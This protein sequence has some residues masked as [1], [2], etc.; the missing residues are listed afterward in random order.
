MSIVNITENGILYGNPRLPIND[1]TTEEVLLITDEIIKIYTY[2]EDYLAF[3]QVLKIINTLP[4]EIQMF[5]CKPI[6]YGFLGIK[7]IVKNV[8]KYDLKMSLSQ[9]LKF[10]YSI[11]FKMG[12]TKHSFKNKPLKYN[13]KKILKFIHTFEFLMKENIYI[14]DVKLD[15]II[16]YNDTFKFIDYQDLNY[17][18]I[19]LIDYINKSIC[20]NITYFVYP[21]D[22]QLFLCNTREIPEDPVN[23]R[24]KRKIINKFINLLKKIKFKK[25]ILFF[26][27]NEYIKIKTHYKNVEVSLKKIDILEHI[28][29]I[30]DITLNEVQ[31]YS[32]GMLLIELLLLY[33]THNDIDDI[34]EIILLCI[35][36]RINDTYVVPNKDYIFKK[37]KIC[38]YLYD[39]IL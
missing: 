13:L 31:L 9:L 34:I 35:I 21:M 33:D 4:E 2:P 19:I 26:T 39:V 17:H 38:K 22:Y 36:H 8:A 6:D 28:K 11:V 29:D 24:H 37:V 23:L 3:E 14:P 5:F 18:D 25:N 15:N 30:K 16:Y 20:N 12:E 27:G 10:S 32:I 7:E 1:E